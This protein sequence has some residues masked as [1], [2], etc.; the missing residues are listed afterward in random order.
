[1]T[2]WQQISD[3][4]RETMV[5]SLLGAIATSEMPMHL[6]DGLVRYFNDGILPG[7]FLQAV[8]C[9]D[10]TSDPPRRPCA[11][12]ARRVP[13]LPVSAGC[14][15]LARAGAR[16]GAGCAG[17]PNRAHERSERGR[18]CSPRRAAG[19]GTRQELVHGDDRSIGL[20]CLEFN[21]RRCVQP[22]ALPRAR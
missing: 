18:R 12:A 1:M 19:T 10:L 4:E 9:N 8:L 22:P 11:A 16:V 13:A 21:R 6:R 5:R 7:S 14:V 2:M 20:R 17:S 3:E 15:A